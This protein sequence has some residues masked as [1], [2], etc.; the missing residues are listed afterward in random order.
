MLTFDDKIVY[1]VILNP[2]YRKRISQPYE[3][4]RQK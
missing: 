4:I 2:I 3:F 1:T